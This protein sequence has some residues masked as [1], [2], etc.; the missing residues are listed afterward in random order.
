MSHIVNMQTRWVRYITLWLF[1]ALAFTAVCAA[2]VNSDGDGAAKAEHFD[3]E[4]SIYLVKTH[5]S[6]RELRTV[7]PQTVVLEDT[8][9]FTIDDVVSYSKSTH[10]IELTDSA[11]KRFIYAGSG[12]PFA[13]CLG[14]KAVYLGVTWSDQSSQGVDGVVAMPYFAGEHTICLKSGYPTE[15]PLDVKDPRANQA[16]FDSIARHG[17]LKN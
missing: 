7:S 2:A 12:Q 11:F 9:L 10:H 5:I 3:K 8:P 14:R 6:W 13:V 1:G 4:F 15:D 16:V 17:K